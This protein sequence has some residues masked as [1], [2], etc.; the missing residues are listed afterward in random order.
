M[1]EKELMIRVNNLKKH[2]TLPKKT[3]FQKERDVV[4]AINEVSFDVNKGETF[5]IVGESGSGKSTI[6]RLINL[7]IRPTD[8]EV[9]YKKQN[10]LEFDSKE[11]AEFRKQ[12]QMVFQ[13]PYGT[14]DPRRSIGY[15][16]EEP[17]TIHSIGTKAERNQRINHLLNLVTLPQS[18][19]NKFPHELSGGQLQRVNIA[20]A[21]ALEPE[22]VICDESVSA[23]DVSVQAQILNLLND[24]QEEL[25]LTY[26]FISHDLNVVRYMCDRIA[27]MNSGEMIE[28]NTAEEIYNNPQKDYT[29]ILLNATPINT[30]HE[31]RT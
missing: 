2:F 19:L 9:Y 26:I 1:S 3:V 12:V 23:L 4:K 14:L 27:V 30:P 16:L 25:N 6:A 22:V 20:R 8:G 31:R 7:L 21:I 15:S 17:F 13:S 18:S 10:I 5:G 11:K 28:L 24:L 29:K